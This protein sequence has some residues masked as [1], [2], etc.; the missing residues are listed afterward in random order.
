MPHA[1][2]RI[3]NIVTQPRRGCSPRLC[4]LLFS[5]IVREK[6][7]GV[8]PFSGWYEVYCMEACF[9]KE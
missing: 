3:R 4:F 7:E 5:G 1:Q 8:L 9:V 6:G 2:P